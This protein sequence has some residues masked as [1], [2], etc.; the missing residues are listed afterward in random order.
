MTTSTQ[1]NK[2]EQSLAEP[3]DNQMFEREGFD[4]RGIRRELASVEALSLDDKYIQQDDQSFADPRTIDMPAGPTAMG[5]VEGQGIRMIEIEGDRWPTFRWTQGFEVLEEDSDD[6]EEQRNAVL[7]LFDF[8][9]DVAFLTGIGPDG[10][11]ADGCFDWLREAIPS[12]RTIDCKEYAD[13]GEYDDRPENIIKKD[14]LSKVDGRLMGMED[15]NWDLMIGSQEALSTFN[16]VSDTGVG[17]V[18]DTY[19]DRLSHENAMG[20]VNDWMLIP[21][22]TA[23]AKVPFDGGEDGEEMLDQFK[24][25]LVKDD[26]EATTSDDE[27]IGKDEVFLLP[28]MDAVQQNYWR[29]HEMGE[30]QTFGPLDLRGGKR[31]YD[32]AWRYTHRFNPQ[33]RHPHATDAIRLT[34]V[35]ELFN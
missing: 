14:A 5:E 6:V 11:Y 34:N 8:F 9:A 27:V 1:S 7:E 32:Y 35:S 19:W 17:V 30:P 16:K 21:D 25:D 18:G 3:L 28:S 2:R 33:R 12:E 23:P 26:A 13:D 20:G 4:R 29:L 31:A 22:F 24:V 10:R 15:A